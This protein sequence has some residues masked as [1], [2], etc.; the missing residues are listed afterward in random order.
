VA[1]VLDAVRSAPAG[2]GAR[3]RASA[4]E[5]VRDRFPVEEVVEAYEAAL[6][7]TAAAGRT[8]GVRLPTRWRT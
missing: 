4:G 8:R 1:E 5:R 6:R 3:L 7:A 2:E